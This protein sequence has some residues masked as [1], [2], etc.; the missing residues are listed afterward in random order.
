MKLKSKLKPLFFGLLIVSGVFAASFAPPLEGT[1]FAD[2]GDDAAGCQ[3]NYQTTGD[4]IDRSNCTNKALGDLSYGATSDTNL[5]FTQTSDPK[6]CTQ[7][8]TVQ[9][10]GDTTGVLSGAYE[11]DNKSCVSFSKVTIKIGA[12][13]DSGGTDCEGSSA[14]SW[15][16]CPIIDGLQKM[17][18]SIYDTLIEPL[19]VTKPLSTAD[20]ASNTTLK[21]W[22]NFRVYGDIF[23]VIGILVIVFGESIGGGLIDAYTAKKVLPRLLI[24]AVLINVSFYIVAVLVDIMNI[25]GKGMMTLITAP[26][27]L[28]GDFKM[29]IGIVGGATFVG[30]LTAAATYIFFSFSAQA[31]SFLLFV[32][33]L[34]LGMVMLAI[35]ATILIRWALI[36]FLVI[37]SPVAFALYCLPNTEKYFRQW[38]DILFKTLLVFPIIASLFAMGKVAGYLLSNAGDSVITGSAGDLLG[39]IALMVPLFLIPFSFKIAGSILGS[40]FGAVDGWRARGHK[41]TEGSRQRIHTQGGKARIQTRQ[42]MYSGIQKRANNRG[43]IGRFGLRQLNKA[44]GGYNIE[45]ATS[46]ARADTS[47]IMNDQ[48]ATG[49]DSEIRGLT[50]NKKWALNSGQIIK[51]GTRAD[52]S[53]G[54]V[55]SDGSDSSF[56]QIR[57]SQVRIGED[58]GRKFKTL[59]G[60]YQSEVDVDNGHNRW[61]KDTFAQQ[62]ALA[63][64]MRKAQSED[65]LANLTDNY[66]AVSQGIITNPDGTEKKVGGGWNMNEQQAGGAWIG[67]A[68]EHQ[69]IHLENK[70]TDWKTGKLDKGGK[71]LVDEMYEKKGSYSV[72]QMGSRSIE[73]LKEA[74]QIAVQTGDTDTQQKIAGI[75]ETFM[76]QMATGGASTPEERAAAAAGGSAG[77]QASTPGSAHVAERVIE[78]AQMSGVYRNAP[79]GGYS[80]PNHAPTPNTRQQ[81]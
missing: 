72:A 21:A 25:V 2:Y 61:G 65:Q 59:G 68:F 70:Y 13:V 42:A 38:W 17:V 75:A 34:P 36:I 45:A 41:F 47:K 51:E 74:H 24:A 44:V 18:G 58:G 50:V 33:L 27:G 37:I 28:T 31:G 62:T 7:T 54:W 43:A 64:E 52:G 49:A 69:G 15:F 16:M 63:Y 4:H 67:G 71:G 22:K 14:V 80:D 11:K 60:S 81:S 5:K 30:L 76:H 35:L 57:D 78:L 8:I 79:P 20:D 55:N 23:L 46:A 12:A 56:E 29:D 6:N 77:R 32:V 48:I 19:L 9:K 26:F 1:A 53:K 10:A 3:F 66:R 39:I 40:A 73:R